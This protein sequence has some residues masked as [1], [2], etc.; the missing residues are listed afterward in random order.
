MLT[1]EYRRRE[2]RWTQ[3][4]VGQLARIGQSFISLIEQGRF[5]PT[6]DQ[7]ARLGRALDIP[8]DEVLKPVQLATVPALRGE[9]E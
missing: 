3:E 8:P 2:K 9:H 4:Q 5:I 1:L 6:P 7:L